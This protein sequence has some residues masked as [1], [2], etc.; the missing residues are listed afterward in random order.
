[1]SDVAEYLGDGSNFHTGT[2]V[3]LDDITDYTAKREAAATIVT[4]GSGSDANDCYDAY[5]AL[6]DAYENVPVNVA[7]PAKIYYIKSVADADKE[8]SYCTG[9]YVHVLSATTNR[10]GKDYNHSHLV[11]DEFNDIT[12]KSLAAFQF[13]AVE[14]GYKIKNLHTGLY[15]KSFGADVEHMGAYADAAVV[16]VSA[17]ADG[18][19]TLQIGD[20]SPMH[21]EK[22]GDVIVQWGAVAGNASLWTIDEAEVSDLDYT[23]T[24][25]ADGYTTLYLPFNVK[26]PEGVEAYTVIP[27][28]IIGKG[29]GEY[30]YV[31]TRVAE[32]GDKLAKGT[33]VIIKGTP[34]AEYTFE[35][36]LDDTDAITV[37]SSALRGTY[38]EKAVNSNETVKAYLLGADEAVFNRI[39][40]DTNIPAVSCWLE[41]GADDE[42]I[43]MY[44]LS[45][46]TDGG[47]YRI[48]GLLSNGKVRTLYNNGANSNIKW[49]EEEKT[50]ASTLFIV[51]EDEEESGKYYL[52]SALASG[53][54]SDTRTIAEEGV[55]L[56]F[57]A[58]SVAHARMIVGNNNRRFTVYGAGTAGEV[59]Y[60]SNCTAPA[61]EFVTENES[62]DFLFESVDASEAKY[63][64]KMK[65]S[66]EWSTLYLPYAVTVPT[67]VKA[68]IATDD[69][70]DDGSGQKVLNLTEAGDIVPAY[71]AVIIKRESSVVA[72]TFNF[73]YTTEAA[74]TNLS[75]NLLKGR[76]TEGYVGGD[77][78]ASKNF[79]ILFRG[80][81]GERM[82]WI[83]KEFNAAGENVGKETGTHIKCA[84]NKAYLALD[85]ANPAPSLSFRFSG[86][87]E[88]EEVKGEYG[89]VKSIYDLQGRK[90]SEITEPG[91]YII[92]GKKVLV[93]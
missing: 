53:V 40:A 91:I 51:K 8:W 20:N 21:G 60:Y 77:D 42:Q 15:V 34:A 57:A 56:T 38:I 74:T 6:R 44:V 49:T 18:Q 65:K 46:I 23:I 68:Y 66:Y 35:A 61:N 9:R 59:N 58:G 5:T 64:L 37:P 26:L 88:I 87:T 30:G 70:V 62:T 29:N 79:Y 16:K 84:G 72:E 32:A 27:S 55:A 47:V 7:D 13:E 63:S 25:P 85:A 4:A 14:G 54:W 82:Y 81:E 80:D 12:H 50:D 69:P 76:I 75:G 43:D 33:A 24:M 71:T 78:M 19:V 52:I 67:G 83:Y 22:A 1:M 10:E 86:T 36:T 92:D 11:F 39:N 73:V 90:L 28:G 45:E 93:K 31:M 2:S 3:G 48:K 89:N 41:A 17:Y